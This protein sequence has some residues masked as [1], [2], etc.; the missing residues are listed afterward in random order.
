MDERRGVGLLCVVA[1]LIAEAPALADSIFVDSQ[2]TG[3]VHDGTSWCNGYRELYQALDAAKPGDVVQTAQ[4]VYQPESGLPFDKDRFATFYLLSGVVIEGGYAGC[5]AENS[6]ERD[7]E[8]YQS[9]LTC[10]RLG[11]DAPE[12]RNRDDN[13]YQVVAAGENQADATAVI[14]GFTISGA[15]GGALGLYR[16]GP[17]IRR[18]AFVDNLPL[19]DAGA[20]TGLYSTPT[21]ESCTFR[22]NR[23]R[24][25]GAAYFL[26]GSATLT[27]CVFEDNA[28][29][30]EPGDLARGGAI[31]NEGG[32]VSIYGS[33][34]RRNHA[35]D[36]GGAIDSTATIV[37][38][39]YFNCTDCIFDSN[40]AAL[41]GALWFEYAQHPLGPFL[42][43]RNSLFVDNISDDEGSAIQLQSGTLSMFACTVVHNR[44]RYRT[45]GGVYTGQFS[46]VYAQSSILWD[47]GT[48]L[49]HVERERQIG[50]PFGGGVQARDSCISG[51]DLHAGLNNVN[52]DPL[53]APGPLGCYYLSHVSTGQIADSPCN[54]RSSVP[55]TILGGDPITTRG[56]E[57]PDDEPL[58]AGFHYPVS[59]RPLIPGD[60]NR[61]G[62]VD[63][64]D[65]FEFQG[66]FA[67][68]SPKLATPCC[69]IFDTTGDLRIS[70]D[71]WQGLVGQP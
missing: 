17:T 31:L 59:G 47:N 57:A 65:W 58:D 13:C 70:L 66:C 21:I 16:S 15:A 28:A 56:D 36:V 60:A 43:I 18:C 54:D 30:G 10:D 63:L 55:A 64:R 24:L 32:Q 61:D 48:A 9:T 68:R 71:D 4:G 20:I 19:N 34:F 5:G 1:A 12:F 23:G 25:G 7:L 37:R 67:G 46:S 22:G 45:G 53:F 51:W 8:R 2:A 50:G 44:N 42:S 3:P 39:G 41:G 69:R 35:N 33:T 26:H 38:Q 29:V 40:S 62:A 27:D 49:R 6:F 14:D 11:D 52:A